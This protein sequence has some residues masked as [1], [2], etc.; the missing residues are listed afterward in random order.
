MKTQS[1]QPNDLEEQF[2]FFPIKRSFWTIPMRIDGWLIAS[3]LAIFMGDLWLFNHEHCP[4]ILRVIIALVPPAMWLLWI[5][6]VA[7]WIRGTDELQRRIILETY[8][9]AITWTLFVIAVLHHLK[10]E[11]ILKVIFRSSHSFLGNLVL[12]FNLG[13]IITEY[14]GLFPLSVML[15]I[16]FL[17]LGYQIFNRRYK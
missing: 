16:S 10:H 14:D 17:I 7:Q 8:L 5:R 2:G 9:F 4:F 3:M 15:F 11:G 13:G 12:G 1:N 6:N